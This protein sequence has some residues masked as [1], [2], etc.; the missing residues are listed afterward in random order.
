VG[1][2]EFFDGGGSP[3]SGGWVAFESNTSSTLFAVDRDHPLV[4][5]PTDRWSFQLVTVAPVLEGGWVF[6]GEAKTKWVAVSRQR[7]ASISAGDET[8]FT[9]QLVGAPGETVTLGYAKVTTTT[10]EGGARTI[11]DAVFFDCVVPSKGSATASIP[12]GKCA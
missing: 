5:P 4:L 11:G 8:G 3:P 1:V 2:D 10:T 7:F 6:L 9:A 12:A